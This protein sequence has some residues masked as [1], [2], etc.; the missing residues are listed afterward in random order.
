VSGSPKFRRGDA[1]DAARGRARRRAAD[2]RGHAAEATALALLLVKG[3]RPLARR[4]RASGGE[5]DLVVAR[6]DTIAFVEVK[7]RAS[8]DAAFVAI[9]ARQ[10]P[11]L[12]P[13]RAG[14]A[15]AKPL[16]RRPH[17]SRG[18]RLHRPWPLPAPPSG[19]VRD[20]DGVSQNPSPGGE[21]QG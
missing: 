3:Y 12:L 17:V 14:V 5:I 9:D 10:A 2:W 4:F 19:G 7:S 21:G 13:R 20:R 6:G 1:L 16:G 8:L 15:H 18:R 11:A